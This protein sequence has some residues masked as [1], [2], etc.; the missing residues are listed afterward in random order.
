MD[1]ICSII[2]SVLKLI[3]VGEPKFG[4]NQNSALQSQSK[5]IIRV[6]DS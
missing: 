1:R 4:T 3:T 6:N 2:P 5:F